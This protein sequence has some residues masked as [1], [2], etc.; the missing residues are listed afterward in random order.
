MGALGCICEQ[1]LPLLP[2]V[3]E[4]HNSLFHCWGEWGEASYTV[5]AKNLQLS[6]ILAHTLF[7]FFIS[8]HKFTVCM[9][10]N[11]F[12]CESVIHSDVTHFPSALQILI[13]S[14]LCQAHG[15]RNA[16]WNSDYL[17][18]WKERPCTCDT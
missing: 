10:N 7:F 3:M 11:D 1:I 6:Y 12:Q 17:R 16:F 4:V 14:P 15:A 13:H 18:L 5:H 2:G 8:H 9:R